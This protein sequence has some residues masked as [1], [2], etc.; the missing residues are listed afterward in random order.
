[1]NVRDFR[2]VGRPSGAALRERL[3]RR[4]EESNQERFSA[5]TPE[6]VAS[7]RST[8]H[9]MTRAVYERQST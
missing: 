4:A 2:S 7:A 1:M 5:L 6:Q 3:H 9:H 8:L